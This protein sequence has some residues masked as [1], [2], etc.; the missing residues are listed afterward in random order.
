VV[1]RPSHV[2]EVYAGDVVISVVGTEFTVE[3]AQ[4]RVGVWVHKGRVRVSSHGEEVTLQT[5]ENRWFGE[6]QEAQPLTPEQLDLEAPGENW[7]ALAGSFEYGRAYEVLQRSGVR[8]SAE[9]LLLAA[10]VA[11]LSGHPAQA[12]PYLLQV[13]RA[14]GASARAALASFT[15]G[16]VLLEN[17]GQPVQAAQAFAEARR[18]GGGSA[19]A[20]DAL[21]REVQA[22]S[23]AG[24]ASN[25]RNLAEQYLKQ[26]P[27]GLHLRAVRALGGLE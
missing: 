21:F 12:V 22:W 5:G 17:L 25:A 6:E 20:E 24:N 13:V 14:H 26:Y 8:D 27:S 16:R 15:L 3:K 9:D 2:F 19:L 11:R 18:L 10:D 7:R 4:Q 1:H 23:Q